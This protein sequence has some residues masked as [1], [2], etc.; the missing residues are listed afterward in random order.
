MSL[1]K[2]NKTNFTGGELSP[3]LLGRGDLRAYEN[4]A[5]LLRNVTIH[6]SGGVT[7]RAGL[8][9]VDTARGNGRL[10]SFEFN[11][12]QV[13]LLI[14]TD[15]YL[16]IYKDDTRIAGL[17]TPWEGSMLKQINWTQSADTLLFVHPDVQPK[18]IT[19]TADDRWD[20]ADWTFV[21]KNNRVFV[22]HYKFVT[23]DTTL[24]PSGLSG[25]IVVTASAPVFQPEHVGT[26]FRIQDR[27]V[28]VTNVR[29][30]VA[31]EAYCKQAL[32]SAS[33]TTDWTEQ[34]YSLVRGFPVSVCFHQDRLVI[35]GSR[36]LPNF[37]WISKSSDLFNFDLGEGLDDEAIE[38]PIL[39]DQVNAI[40]HVFSGRH[41]QVFTSGAE[42]MVSGD[43]LTASSIQVY[44][45][46][47][48][49]SPVD[50][51]I[52]PRDVDGATIFVPRDGPQIR[53]FLYTD[54]EQAYQ[55]NDLAMLAHHLI[56]NSVDMDFEKSSRLL[57]VVMANG[58]MATLTIFRDEQISAWTL[59][60]T[61]G[62]F[63]SVAAVG[64]Q[65]YVLVERSGGVFVE[66]FDGTIFVDAGLAGTA[67]SPRTKW[68]GLDHLE[69]M[70]VK[71]VADEAMRTDTLVQGG[72]IVLD[73]GARSVTAGLGYSHI[74][75]P[76]PPSFGSFGTGIGSKV[77]PVSATFRFWE[78]G[79]LRL[80]TGRGLM[81]ISFKRMGNEVLDSPRQRFS[82][83][84]TI[85]ANGWRCGTLNPIW[86]IEQDTP[87]PFTLLSVSSALS[88]NG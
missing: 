42:W 14:L 76:L 83:D 36:E 28:E 38:F 69:G 26:R 81:D 54:T 72:E 43:P 85:R 12:Q 39:S 22:P 10:F 25:A 56:D 23:S 31:M 18:K 63:K 32:I 61:A 40:R 55:S 33:E 41:L 88:V 53:E 52:P 65:T 34:A 29:S 45:Q 1:S 48:V 84:K 4:G 16:D 60:K 20:L 68:G 78:T 71:V 70:T 67:D 3:L 79:A 77:R 13:Y 35:G 6:P 15:R 44:R 64:E 57:Y 75:E 66:V 27:E 21:E 9:F 62:S 86:R 74:I 8:R 11:T 87:L 58:T 59:Q 80:D 37:L 19:R 7:R 51:T 17:P 30:P 5:R 24:K 73:E 82:G 2:D 46:T 49:G 50:R 47:R